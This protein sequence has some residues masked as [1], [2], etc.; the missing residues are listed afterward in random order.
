MAY[1]I[2]DLDHITYS[3]Y[4][5]T[6]DFDAEDGIGGDVAPEGIDFIPASDS[7]TGEA[8]IITGCEV[9]GTMPVISLTSYPSNLT[10]KL[11]ILHTNDTHGG[12]VAVKGDSIGTAGVAKLKEQY[13]AAGADVLLISAGDVIQGDPLVNLSKGETA[14]DFMNLASY[15]LMTPGNHEFDYGYNNLLERESQ[16]N[17]PFV[18]ANILDKTSGQ[19]VFEPY[20]IFN[21]SVG[22]V[23]VFG[24]TT[25]ESLTKAN[26]KNV[27]SLSFPAGD[28]MYKIAQEQVDTL[29][30]AGC[31]K[32]IAVGHLGTDEGSAPNTSTDVIQHVTGIDLFID[33]HSHSVIPSQ[34]VGSTILTSAG[35]KLEEVGVVTMDQSS[36]ESH[37][38]S[39]HDYNEVDGSIDAK[40]NTVSKAIDEALSDTFATTEVLLD[41]NRS[42]GV[43]TQETNLGD[44]AADAMLWAANQAV[45]EGTVDAAITNGGG[46]RES[47]QVGPIT[48]KDMKTVFPFGNTIST[49]KI[50]GHQLLEVLEA[51]TY[52]TPDSLGAF[53]QVAGISFTINTGI[54]YTPGAQY[55][56]STYYGPAKPGSRVT[57][58]MIAGAPLD[59]NKTYTI[60][61][62]DFLTAGGDTYYVFS[63][64][65]DY[66][67]YVALEDA[68]VNY[69]QK[70]LDNK[71]IASEYGTP[72]G[73]ITLNTTATAST[74]DTPTSV[75]ADTYLVQEGDTLTSIAKET[76][77]DSARYIE[78]YNLNLN[79]LT[80]PN[81]I[82]IGQTLAIPEQ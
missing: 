80:N 69:T 8:L 34:K 9:T 54:S 46:I 35:S 76:L 70:V 51:S 23:G 78:I 29:K 75:D 72:K 21:A 65:E 25:P 79:L 20:K 27:A 15:D 5:N 26:P 77:G 31:V 40:I 30:A 55:P 17:F 62:N 7:V 16:A 60:A 41:G 4:I 13:K 22:K 24:L 56:N 73:R 64:C 48:M 81:L 53:P 1:D 68:M 67:T 12:D 82:Y 59:L 57:D 11:V 52:S 45:G 33:G 19:P 3:N 50:T 61:T 18:S 58:V 38:I 42:P 14:I 63:E 2:T 71:V 32:I 36:I 74:V 44:F 28:D 49:L 39:A 43:R 10:G 37:L 6:R 66:N 47:I